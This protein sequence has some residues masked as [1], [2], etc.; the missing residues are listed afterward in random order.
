MKTKQYTVIAG[1]V[2]A[3]ALISFLL[4]YYGRQHKVVIDNRT[5]E[6][7]DGQSFRA[8]PGARV[9][10]EVADLERG[11]TPPPQAPPL[12]SFRFWPLPDQSVG[13]AVEMTPRERIMVKVIGPSFNLKADVFNN[14]GETTES[15]DVNIHL[16]TKRD[17]MVRLVKLANDLPDHLEEFPNDS[18]PA[19]ADDPPPPAGGEGPMTEAPALGDS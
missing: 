6:T 15:L 16:G 4:F 1:L 12:I 10:V 9:G 18:R 5:V 11:Q 14:M 3:L 13:Q 7:P 19:A 8:L 2:A 17:A